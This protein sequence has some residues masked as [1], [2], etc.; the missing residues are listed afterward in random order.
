V[1]ETGEVLPVGD[2]KAKFV[3]VRIIAATNKNLE[4]QISKGL[5]REDLFYRLNVIEVKIPP[6]RER[7]EDISV[8]ARHFIEKYSRENNKKVSGLADEAMD[9]LNAYSWPGNI[10]ELRNVIERAVVLASGDKIGLAELSDRIKAQQGMRST[11][12]L[13]DKMDSYE[14]QIIRETL[15]VHNGNKETAAKELDVDLATL[16]RKIKKLGI[17]EG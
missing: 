8:L 4:E 6:L 9:V 14:S 1:L 10:R 17:A 3:D 7:K 2:T 12:G 15:L 5:F 11:Q 16:Y 13:K